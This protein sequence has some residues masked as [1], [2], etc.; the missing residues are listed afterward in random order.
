M[1]ERFISAAEYLI[2]K[3]VKRNDML[4]GIDEMSHIDYKFPDDL[5]DE[6]KKALYKVKSTDPRDS[7]ITAQRHL[8]SSHPQFKIA[9]LVPDTENRQNAD[10]LE[11]ALAQLYNLA[12][13][14]KLGGLTEAICWEAV[15]Y[16][17][18]AGQV[19]YIPHE[20]KARKT[21]KGDT[22]GLE[23]AQHFGPFAVE[24]HNAKDVHV[25]YSSWGPEMVLLHKLMPTRE[26]LQLFGDHA[27]GVS[28]KFKKDNGLEWATVFDLQEV[29]KRWVGVV[30]HADQTLEQSPQNAISVIDGEDTGLNFL[31]WFVQIS[32]T[33]SETSSEHQII[34]MLKSV[35]DSGQ[36]ETLCALQSLVF[37]KVIGLHYAATL[38]VES[39]TGDVPEIIGTLDSPIVHVPFGAKLIPIDVRSLDQGMLT[40]QDMVK[41]SIDKATVPRQ[42]QTGEFPSGTPMGAVS[43]ITETGMQTITPFRNAAARAIADIGWLMF[44]WIKQSGEALQVD[45]VGDGNHVVIDPENYDLKDLY[46]D[47]TLQ[48]KEPLALVAR[49]NAAGMMMDRGVQMIRAYEKMNIPDP[50]KAIKEA[51]Q[52][53]IE[54][55]ILEGEVGV[56]RAGYE[57]EQQRILM[58]PQLEAQ[59]VMEQQAMAQEQQLAQE[60]QSP[61][62]PGFN[63]ADGGQSSVAAGGEVREEVT[64]MTPEGIPL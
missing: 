59:Q 35:Y 52:E 28:R 25:Q 42:L 40:L 53:A 8:A 21:F 47:V 26:V 17:M 2:E 15:R 22:R 14:R 34:P 39:P 27:K 55:V 5:P 29:G 10:K 49:V 3:D 1:D 61:G 57:A 50:Q 16:A 62:G 33:T 46:I 45:A 18:V 12:G 6:F 13:R 54:Q 48:P 32:G 31:N 37:S 51:Q 7:L 64:G 11:L 44:A 56:I 63:P 20:I 9:H 36:W 60:G 30:L 19:M 4:E 38:G 41:A 43:I 23:L 58:Q 24:V